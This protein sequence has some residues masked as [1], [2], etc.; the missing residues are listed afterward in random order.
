MQLSKVSPA[1]S[2]MRC[3][4]AGVKGAAAEGGGLAGFPLVLQIIS[5]RLS[6]CAESYVLIA[7][8]FFGVFLFLSQ[9][10][11]TTSALADFL[12]GNST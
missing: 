2:A 10:M 6:H 7:R 4:G 1:K 8:S 11:Q 3:R 9:P 12:F 5:A